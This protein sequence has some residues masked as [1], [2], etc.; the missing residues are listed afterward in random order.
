MDQVIKTISKADDPHYKTPLEFAKWRVNEL[1]KPQQSGIINE[2]IDT[3]IQIVNGILGQYNRDGGDRQFDD[4]GL[5]SALWSNFWEKGRKLNPIVRFLFGLATLVAA[6]I[7]FV[8]NIIRL[9]PGIFTSSL[10]QSDWF[11]TKVGNVGRVIVPLI[12]YVT[13][14]GVTLGSESNY[15]IYRLLALLLLYI[16]SYTELKYLGFM[17]IFVVSITFESIWLF[18]NTKE[19]QNE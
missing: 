6:L 13:L 15:N 7:L 3:V 18:F 9:I 14:F 10:Y 5:N 11:I 12:I 16:I 19:N 1:Q 17:V 2:T 8:S 4:G